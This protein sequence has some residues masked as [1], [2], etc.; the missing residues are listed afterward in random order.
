LRAI[1]A[2]GAYD[3]RPEA[4]DPPHR[5][6][7]PSGRARLCVRSRTADPG[8]GLR[9]HPP[10]RRADHHRLH[11][12]EHACRED[13]GLQRRRAAR[14]RLREH[15]RRTV[16]ALFNDPDGWHAST[17]YDKGV[18][19]AP[20]DI[21]VADLWGGAAPE[22]AV[23]DYKTGAVSVL[24][25]AGGGASVTTPL[26]GGNRPSAIDAG[27]LDGDGRA[28]L[29]VGTFGG[30]FA[31]IRHAGDAGYTTTQIG[32]GAAYALAIGSPDGDGGSDVIT[33]SDTG[34]ST[35]RNRA[36]GWD[37]NGGGGYRCF[38]GFDA[39]SLTSARAADAMIAVLPSSGDFVELVTYN[40]FL[41]ACSSLARL[42]TGPSPTGVAFGDFNADGRRDLAT[43]NHGD[44]TVSLLARGT[45]GNGDYARTTLP[46]GPA[47]KRIV[48]G[49][50]DGDGLS[51]IV[52]I[53]EDQTIS[54]L[55]NT[56]DSV[57]PVSSDDVPAGYRDAPISVE[58]TARDGGGAQA[59]SGV[60]AV[61][62]RIVGADGVV[63]A[64][65]TYDDN[66]RPVL[67]HGEKVRYWA[68]D[69]LGN[70]EAAHDS[71][72]AKVDQTAP[73]T[74]DDVPSGYRDAPV[75]VTLLAT[76]EGSGVAAIRYRVVDVNGD[77]GEVRIYSASDKPALRDGEKLRY[78]AEDAVGN[79]EVAHDSK[80]AQV[81]QTAPSTRDDVPSAYG[82]EP[83]TV[84]LTA[85]D[86]GSGLAQT[87][88]RIV[89]A[90]GDVG[91]VQTYSSS[92]RPVL[93]DGEKVRYST[94]DVVG[95]AEV[96]H[97]SPAAKVDQ[98]AP[99][100]SDDLRSGYRD[101]PV[102]VTLTG[103]D[104]GGS[105]VAAITFQVG[106]ADGGWGEEQT[107]S[108]SQRP[109]L[110]HGES[111]RYF[112]VDR[113]GNREG[114]HVSGPA[115]VD[116]A[117]PSTTDNV[118]SGD[119][120][121]LAPVAVTLTAVDTGGSGVATTKYSVVAADGAV[122]EEQTYSDANRPLLHDGEKLAYYTV[123]GAGNRE[124]TRRSSAAKVDETAPSTSDNVPPGY[125]SAPV[126]VTL[127]PVDT[128]GSGVAQTTYRI[129][130]P[131]GDAGQEQI[132]SGDN[133]PVLLDGQ[134]VRYSTVDH[135]GHRE[136]E[137]DS[138]AAKVDEAAPSTSDDVPSGYQAAVVTVTLTAEDPGNSGIAETK[139]R[140]VAADGSVGEE[141]TYSEN[142]RP[143]LRD[144]QRLRY[145]AIDRAG[146]VESAHASPA[147]K[148]DDVAP[149][150]TDDVP[151]E[152]RAGPIPVSLT[153]TDAGVG[154]G[155]G[156]I[157]FRIVAA[158]GTEGELQSLRDARPVL[159]DGERV[160]YHAVDALGNSEMPH[161]SA[162]AK[163]DRVAPTTTDDVPATFSNAPVRVTLTAVDSGA[164]QGMVTRYA[165]LAA[166]GTPGAERLYD[167]GDKPLLRDGER[168]RYFSRDG[169]GNVGTRRTSRAAM[170][171]DVAPTTSDDVSAALASA[172]VV[173]TLTATDEG[174][175]GG[176]ETTYAIV[177]VAGVAG[178][179]QSYSAGDRPR[180]G[181]GERIR[182]ATRDGAGN[183][184]AVKTSRAVRVAAP[185][186]TAAP[187]ASPA[188]RPTAPVRPAAAAPADS[189]A[190]PA[191]PRIVLA[192][193][194]LVAMRQ[195]RAAVGCTV[196][197]GVI[198]RCSARLVDAHDAVLA[199]GGGGAHFVLRPTPA[200][201]R[202][203]R[204]HP[205]GV[206]A[207][208]ELL[209]KAPSGASALTRQTVA[210]VD[211]SVVLALSGRS[212]RL[213]VAIR[214]RIAALAAAFAPVERVSCR[215]ATQAQAQAA[216]DLIGRRIPAAKR[217][218]LARPTS[219]GLM[220][221][222]GGKP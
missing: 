100:S 189:H 127:I 118:P 199:E 200:G 133:R 190:A 144:G 201:R 152:Y 5:A 148:V 130:Q 203:L 163:V 139:Y 192:S 145:W 222:F 179:P 45:G 149:V 196:R 117:A 17:V 136:P 171:D 103:V 44:G 154:V 77:A 2:P 141:R 82:N 74:G 70:S 131:S 147:A 6:H 150:S 27:D 8:D 60:V 114:V 113:A 167:A 99:S 52:T 67:Q 122:G 53:N 49:D 12:S 111:V 202:A 124:A 109:V 126:T 181:D 68:Q 56:T 11:G 94:S 138:S 91:D 4:N 15:E 92:N 173:V 62:Y 218:V 209:V 71:P 168:I 43:S 142:Q 120:I 58:L 48:A 211:E 119:E 85:T 191:R 182:Y 129:I 3:P 180:L 153:S 210:L 206:K 172:P 166:D 54:L 162:A 183:V 108:E 140:V 75:R 73:A 7:P 123:D 42:G 22:I 47:P 165:I 1:V 159:G 164:T 193:R 79:V 61:H 20:V 10:L 188:E 81:D 112:A 41:R 175:S 198:A 170:V 169:V 156:G 64:E 66:A 125:R 25:V 86:E 40:N 102:T 51:D 174:E 33:G 110:R 214:R 212:G 220:L 151:A 78:S 217:T 155:V 101:A 19:G 135:A 14:P 105:G 146:N 23:A 18:D 37:T 89:K 177:S 13:R 46:T 128:G 197:Q 90:D 143:V 16:T 32:Q 96:A 21:A 116:E 176:L 84:T 216:C 26:P 184:E 137:H 59:A 208:L 115:L 204:R 72:A 57:A 134:K 87:T 55:R 207:T 186:A 63:G 36:T 93:Q 31:L 50:F 160:R 221:D 97:D 195:S 28:D 65:Q 107:Y 213:P 157:V 161:L 98:A 76:E 205:G 83:V 35:Y 39:S 29:A 178:S 69:A 9:H 215:A 132:Y 121:A 187:D 24:D 104:T 219:G 38:L 30:P 185:V 106:W 158:D 80:A 194:G 95:N 34:T 88:Y